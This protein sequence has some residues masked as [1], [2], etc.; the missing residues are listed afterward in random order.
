MHQKQEMQV[1]VKLLMTIRTLA[2]D[3]ADLF[4]HKNNRWFDNTAS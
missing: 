3:Y 1:L 2:E 4:N